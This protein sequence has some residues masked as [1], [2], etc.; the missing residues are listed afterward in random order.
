MIEWL[1]FLYGL[2]K[3]LNKYLKWT[4]ESKLVNT[5]WL[6]K[7]GFKTQME[8]EGFKLRWSRPENIESR[9]LDG[10]EI[11]YQVDKSKRIRYRLVRIDDLVLIGRRRES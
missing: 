7:S 1:G 10:W 9:R 5:T 6:G 8:Q 4:E 2:T 11:V 3:D